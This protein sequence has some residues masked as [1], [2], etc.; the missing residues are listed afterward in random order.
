MVVHCRMRQMQCLYPPAATEQP[1][2][3]KALLSPHREG[4]RKGSLKKACLLKYLKYLKYL[5][6]NR[7]HWSSN[8]AVENKKENSNNIHSSLEL[9]TFALYWIARRDQRDGLH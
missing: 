9:G 8:S 4:D 1:Y 6:G 5:V 3:G 2:L 7:A